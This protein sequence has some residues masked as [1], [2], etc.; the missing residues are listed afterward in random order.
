[1]DP[2]RRPTRHEAVISRADSGLVIAVER[3]NEEWV[4]ARNAVDLLAH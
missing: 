2:T 1:M 4:A 3:T